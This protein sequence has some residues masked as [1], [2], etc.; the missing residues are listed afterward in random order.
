MVVCGCIPLDP[1]CEKG[2]GPFCL[3]VKMVS[4]IV[5]LLY[6]TEETFQKVAKEKFL[7]NITRIRRMTV[8]GKHATL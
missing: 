4:H 2:K 3:Y 6:K 7:V 1:Y 5:Q 8:I